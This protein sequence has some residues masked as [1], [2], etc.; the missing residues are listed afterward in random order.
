M[1]GIKGIDKI[2]FSPVPHSSSV[3]IA[4]D[5]GVLKTTFSMEAVKGELDKDPR[6]RCVYFSFKDPVEFLR[7]RFD[8]APYEEKGQLRVYDYDDF[9]EYSAN[10]GGASRALGG[11][12]KVARKAD[13]QGDTSLSMVVLDP[14]NTMLHHVASGNIRN[15]VY[16][17][18]SQLE[19]L[20]TRNMVIC[21]SECP[22]G[23]SFIRPCRF[24]ADGIIQLG[25]Q[26][27]QDDVIRYME[28]LKMRGVHHS[29]KRFQL[30]YRQKELKVLGPTYIS[31]V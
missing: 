25:M 18:F 15:Y 28:V 19:E 17:L 26:E 11:L 2:I 16:H 13:D 27:T 9:L 23:D 4:G 8:I 12:L 30:S 31:A 22:R 7:R 14:I 3:I 20:K 21:E 10:G 24:L 6:G 29:L 5:A 1:L